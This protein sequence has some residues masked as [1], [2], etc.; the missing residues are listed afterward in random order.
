MYLHIE[1][2]SFLPAVSLYTLSFFRQKSQEIPSRRLVLSPIFE[3]SNKILVPLFDGK[4]P[5]VIF[6]TAKT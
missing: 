1:T 4:K 6:L 3:K 2:A 5:E